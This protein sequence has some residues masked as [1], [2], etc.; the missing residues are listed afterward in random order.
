MGCRAVKQQTPVVEHDHLPDLENQALWNKYF[1]Q[2]LG[3]C[4][5]QH[6]GLNYVPD[7]RIPCRA[8]PSELS[9]KEMSTRER[10]SR[11]FQSLNEL[12]VVYMQLKSQLHPPWLALRFRQLEM[13]ARRSRV[14]DI[15]GQAA[16]RAQL[17]EMIERRSAV[18]SRTADLLN[19]IGRLPEQADMSHSITY[20][21]RLSGSKPASVQVAP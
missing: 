18:T 3:Q 7:K 17:I 1:D 4:V 12:A 2:G 10:L 20:Y 19:P 14:L 6:G 21:D 5:K 16:M 9:Q 8:K 15:A 11:E 13:E